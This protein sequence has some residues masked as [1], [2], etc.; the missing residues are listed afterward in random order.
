MPELVYTYLCGV[1]IGRVV[2]VMGQP[3]H[4]PHVGVVIDGTAALR[5]PD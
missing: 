2:H 5:V 1:D 4:Q 3:R